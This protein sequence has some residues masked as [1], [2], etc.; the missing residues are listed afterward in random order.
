MATV[1]P[2]CKAVLESKDKRCPY[3]RTPIKANVKDIPQAEFSDAER[4]GFLRDRKVNNSNSGCMI[5]I[6]LPI[7]AAACLW[8]LL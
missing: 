5:F 3:C 7:A 6:L 4:D 2:K 1:C 8:M